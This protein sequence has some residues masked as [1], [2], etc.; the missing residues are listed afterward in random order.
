MV[1]IEQ[2]EEEEVV[3]IPKMTAKERRREERRIKFGDR[4]ME[5][6]KDGVVIVIKT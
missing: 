5:E 4:K 1:D 6:G 2:E 3:V